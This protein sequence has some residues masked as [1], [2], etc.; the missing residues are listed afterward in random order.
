[1]SPGEVV[2]SSGFNRL[3]EGQKVRYNL[4]PKAE[5]A[6]ASSQP[7]E[8]AAGQTAGMTPTIS[9]HAR[10]TNPLSYQCLPNS[11]N[12]AGVTNAAPK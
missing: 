4:A 2:A 6:Q 10:G 3:G 11:T 1:M 5:S 9:V 7:G 8:Q 12:A